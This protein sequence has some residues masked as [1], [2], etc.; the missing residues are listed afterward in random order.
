MLLRSSCDG[1]WTK[2]GPNNANYNK[3][4]TTWTIRIPHQDLRSSEVGGGMI[5]GLGDEDRSQL[6]QV[7]MATFYVAVPTCLRCDLSTL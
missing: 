5:M 7:S 2:I 4:R 3:L 6:I 1:Q